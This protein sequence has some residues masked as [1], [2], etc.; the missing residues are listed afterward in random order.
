MYR[1]SPPRPRWAARIPYPQIA[2]SLNPTHSEALNNLGVLEYRKG[3]DESAAA[4]F[5]WEAGAP[6]GPE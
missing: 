2:I 1:S 5:R 3:N 4:L 6:G